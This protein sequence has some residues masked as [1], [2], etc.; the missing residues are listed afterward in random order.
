MRLATRIEDLPPYL[1]LDISRKIEQQRAKGVKIISF[2]IGDP[3]LPTPRHVVDRIR[4]AAQE[5]AN[6]RY[7]ETDGLPALRESISDWYKKR[8]GVTLDP[9][10]EV[11]PLIG[12]KEGIGHMSFCLINPGD[13]ALVPTPGYPVYSVSTI[14]AGGVP[15][16]L[17]LLENNNFLPDL[18]SIPDEIIE[19]AKVLW[20]NYPNNP[21][22]AV[23]DLDFFRQ[24]V[25]FANRH[26]II[27]CH[28][29]PYTEVAFDG[30]QPPSFLEADGAKAVGVEFH[31]LSKTYNMTG[32]R[33]GMAVGNSSLI[34]A[35]TRIKS[36]LDSGI[37]Q[38]IQYAAI[39]ALEGPR[40]C[41][42]DHNAV[43]QR[44]RDLIIDSLS[45]MGFEVK[46][47]KASLYIW[48]KLPSGES[49]ASFAARLI[50]DTGVVVTPGIGYGEGGEGYIRFSL[51]ISD[52]DL[53]EGLNRLEKWYAA[54]KRRN[55]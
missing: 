39:R 26:D 50:E 4:E 47:P 19:R 55:L 51:T 14:L 48:T 40:D 44:R 12:S 31:T 23:V 30:Y 22:G 54:S 18:A 49:S 16:Y 1:F 33:V 52:S 29:A 41:I 8:F 21:T 46:P 32:W 9:A 27:V 15:Y 3:D 34:D 43:Y 35:L 20:L 13:I 6:H 10:K 38:A 28:D 45:R 7:P 25:K 36:N 17:P 5:P 42:D 37:P 53:I 2:G 11:L 24:V